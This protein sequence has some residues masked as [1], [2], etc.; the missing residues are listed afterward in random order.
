MDAHWRRSQLV[1]IDLCLEIELSLINRS[2]DYKGP[3][4]SRTFNR[5]FRKN[6]A[7]RRVLRTMIEG[8]V[9]IP[10]AIIVILGI[11]LALAGRFHR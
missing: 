1:L 11:A 8:G 4:V 3:S 10:H 2:A 6:H 7:P 5:N 9:S